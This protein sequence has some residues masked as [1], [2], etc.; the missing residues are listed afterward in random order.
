MKE[1]FVRDTFTIQEEPIDALVSARYLKGELSQ[2]KKHIEKEFLWRDAYSGFLF[3]I[4]IIAL[5]L[6]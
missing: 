5:F 6:K 1:K 3:L 4:L 2:M